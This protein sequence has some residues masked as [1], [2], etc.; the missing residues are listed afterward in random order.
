MKKNI[1]TAQ[2]VLDFVI[3]EKGVDS[4][5]K[6][7]FLRSK[8]IDKEVL[9][10]AQKRLENLYIEVKREYKGS[11]IEL[12]QEEKLEGWCW[13]TTETAIVFFNDDDYIERGEINLDEECSWYY[14]S[15]ICFKFGE[16]EYVLD[17]CLNI[18]CK[19][20][21]YYEVYEPEVKGKV[22]AKEVK[23]ELIRQ[24]L[25]PKKETA[26]YIEQEF[27]TFI[28]SVVSKKSYKRVEE[29]VRMAYLD[30]ENSPFFRNG[31]GYT[32]EI[33][34]GEIKKLTVHFYETI[35]Y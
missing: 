13:Q 26:L 30:D 21:N 12:M 28:K 6:I 16:E 27:Q 3:N 35:W 8:I 18:L 2:D 20:S 24:M 10:Y 7:N 1:L 31:S 22:T 5:K 4:S 32:G 29:E 9:I 14:H 19:K 11:L 23:E 15:W 33:N 17:P 34:N 25:A